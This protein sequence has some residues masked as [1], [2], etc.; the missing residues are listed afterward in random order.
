MGYNLG[1][2]VTIQIEA[3]Y[4]GVQEYNFPIKQY[5]RGTKTEQ[6][7][8]QEKERLFIDAQLTEL[9]NG[10]VQVLRLPYKPFVL[11]FTFGA[12]KNNQKKVINM[13]QVAIN[14]NDGSQFPRNIRR[15]QTEINSN[16]N[17]M[18]A[19]DDDVDHRI[20]SL[21]K[22]ILSINNKQI[23]INWIFDKDDKNHIDDTYYFQ[24]TIK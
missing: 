5:H 23:G 10:M 4:Q 18:I 1:K 19:V 16:N 13:E 22:M 21:G 17:D 3:T 11:R 2:G 12:N 15:L 8:E 9:S 24:S 20:Y 14:A 7:T 6:E